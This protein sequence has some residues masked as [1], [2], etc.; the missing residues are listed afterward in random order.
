MKTT[1]GSSC[2]TRLLTLE[3]DFSDVVTDDRAR[4]KAPNLCRLLLVESSSDCLR[5]I[6]SNV[7][8]LSLQ[9]PC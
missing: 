5:Q 8:I 1:A 4:M 3:G 2:S 7:Y 9:I 6:I